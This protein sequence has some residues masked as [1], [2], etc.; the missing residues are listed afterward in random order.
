MS[1]ALMRC[2]IRALA[3][4]ALGAAAA[5]DDADP[6]TVDDVCQGGLRLPAVVTAR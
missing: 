4:L 1:E 5:C 3:P 2:N 6:C